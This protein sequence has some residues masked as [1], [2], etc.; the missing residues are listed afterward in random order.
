M[1]I[2]NIGKW[3]IG[4]GAALAFISRQRLSIAVKGVYLSGIITNELI[5]L[6]VVVYLI[7]KTIAS[8][9]IR[10]ISGALFSDGVKVATI[11]Q[12]INKRIPANSTTEQSIMVD[13]HNRE[14]LQAIMANIQS[15][16]INNLSFEF[17]GEI[18]VGEQFPVGI[19]FNKLFTWQDIQQMV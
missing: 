10:S 8:V 13:I 16:D 6:R 17:V 19:K 3:L 5:P 9:L 1:R 11:G 4:I 14:A 7:N 18:V 15:G 12:T 2:N